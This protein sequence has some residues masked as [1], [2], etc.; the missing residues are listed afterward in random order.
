MGV[1]LDRRAVK[2]LQVAIQPYRLPLRRPWQTAAGRLDHR[3]GFLVRVMD[4]DGLAGYGEAAPLPGHAGEPLPECR[5][6][7]VGLAA[8]IATGL[9]RI[10]LRM[11]VL[12]RLALTMRL[13]SRNGVTA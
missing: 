12:L 8:A 4:P 7:L 2:R 13:S 6:G 9:R 1:P 10:V 11:I 3:E 5:A